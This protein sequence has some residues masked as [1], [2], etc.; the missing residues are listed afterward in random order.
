LPVS[1]SLH[2]IQGKLDSFLVQLEATRRMFT[3]RVPA[4]IANMGPGFDS[5]GMAVNLYN[6]F[7]FELS[8]QD[9][10][11]F[12]QG[13]YPDMGSDNIL[14]K[15]MDTLYQRAGQK[16][17]C[18][19]VRTMGDIPMTG[20]LGSSSTAV[21]AGL[22]AANNQLEE[23]F[24]REDLLHTA[25]E[26]EGHPDN[27]APALLGGVLLYDTQPYHLPWPT[28]WRI[29]TL[30]PSYSVLTEEA[31][32]ILPRSVALEDSIFNLRKA[33]VLTYAL[34]QKNADALKMALQDRLHQPY[35]RKL[36]REYDLLEQTA[37]DAGALGFIISG[38]GSTM[39]AF[40]QEI[41]HEK[42][43]ESIRGVILQQGWN[44]ILNDLTIDAIGA[45]LLA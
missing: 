13:K 33:S 1:Y 28:E 15:A 19:S 6:H 24:S 29:L 14:F 11:A 16:R 31:R 3:V 21:I 42:I 43:L 7:S 9:R 35:R 20:G 10:L 44:I 17:P 40:Y 23:S 45:Q 18:F 41:T 8:E 26:I 39:A 4:T 5:F 25:I 2:H 34:L 12:D 36:I 22:I 30:S 38:S 27:V 37:L 32:Q